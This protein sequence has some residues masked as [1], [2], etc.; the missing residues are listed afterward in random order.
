MSLQRRPAFIGLRPLASARYAPPAYRP[1][2]SRPPVAVQL[3]RAATTLSMPRSSSILAATGVPRY[4]ASRTIQPLIA[5][6]KKLY[7]EEKISDLLKDLQTIHATETGAAPWDATIDGNLAVH[8]SDPNEVYVLDTLGD[9]LKELKQEVDTGTW[10]V[11]NSASNT[12]EEARLLRQGEK[13]SRTHE[14]NPSQ[15]HP[16]AKGFH[17][18]DEHQLL[19]PPENFRMFRSGDKTV[20]LKEKTTAASTHTFE[21]DTTGDP[22]RPGYIMTHDG[23]FFG[24]LDM[25]D[26]TGKWS[27][28]DRDQEDRQYMQMGG[29]KWQNHT[30]GHVSPFEHSPFVHGTQ[31]DAS[32]QQSHVDVDRFPKAK[33]IE[34]P[35]VGEQIKRAQVEAR[36]M[37]NKTG[38]LQVATYSTSSPTMS[39]SYNKTTAFPTKRPDQLHF[40]RDVGTADAEWASFDNTGKTRYDTDEKTFE[41]NG[42]YDRRKDDDWYKKKLRSNQKRVRSGIDTAAVWE[43]EAKK[44]KKSASTTTFTSKPSPLPS[45][46]SSTGYDPRIEKIKSDVAS[47]STPP[48]SPA[49][50]TFGD[51]DNITVKGFVVPGNEVKDNSGKTVVVVRVIN[52]DLEK[53]ESEVVVQEKFGEWS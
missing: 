43:R 7:P 49:Y 44:T 38:F 36:M 1:G 52:Y 9:L 15:P 25:Y 12:L 14:L 48:G 46:L 11:K 53:N 42:D 51:E 32:D 41:K 19:T 13:L 4:G 30:V 22:D 18:Y 37:K 2:S 6:G 47:Y 3:Y 10:N 5:I 31:T 24:N 21:V 23:N 29:Y 27:W 39:A 35:A 33:V 26:D 45:I 34:N 40:R 28:Q 20:F 8:M 16:I 50:H 17:T